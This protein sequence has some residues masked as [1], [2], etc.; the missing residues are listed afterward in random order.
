MIVCFLTLFLQ[1]IIVCLQCYFWWWWAVWT[2]LFWGFLTKNVLWKDNTGNASTE[3]FAIHQCFFLGFYYK[4]T[5]SG[6]LRAPKSPPQIPSFL[7]VFRVLGWFYF[8]GPS[9]LK[10]FQKYFYFPNIYMGRSMYSEPYSLPYL[11]MLHEVDIFCVL[12][13]KTHLVACAA[14]FACSIWMFISYPDLSKK[15]ENIKIFLR[16]KIHFKKL[17]GEISS[18]KPSDRK[19]FGNFSM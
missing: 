15:I 6:A 10:F 8:F 18:Q 12:L 14:H 3:Y 11:N 5:F 17:R 16:R 2:L 13:D 9:D 19:Q 1:A 7:I 4:V